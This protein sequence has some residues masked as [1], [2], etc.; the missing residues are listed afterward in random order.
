M[1]RP[2]FARET[3]Q[4]VAKDG[5]PIT[6]ETLVI[7]E[8]VEL[9]NVID[10]ARVMGIYISN[11][12][13][14]PGIQ[15]SLNLLRSLGVPIVYWADGQSYFNFQAFETAMFMLTRYG[16]PGFISAAGT[17]KYYGS[18][19]IKDVPHHITVD[20]IRKYGKGLLSDMQATA[21]LRHVQVTRKMRRL[22]QKVGAGAVK[23]AIDA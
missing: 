18:D 21:N 22:A 2:T 9:H 10:F 11:D 7:G 19:F 15:K 16:G 14:R 17:A 20:L 8:T 6:L 1:S 23:E 12:R 13:T 4:A 5:Q 3:K